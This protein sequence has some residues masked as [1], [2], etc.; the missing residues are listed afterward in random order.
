MSADYDAIPAVRWSH[1]K[2]IDRSP[3]HYLHA[4]REPR[5]DTPA[6]RFGR[7][8]HCLVLEPEAWA[9]RY[10]VWDGYRRGKA[11]DAF[12]E[13]NAHLEIVNAEEAARVRAIA[14]AI[15]RHPV[16]AEAL[17]H[18]VKEGVLTWTDEATGLACK[19]RFDHVNGRLV[20]LKTAADVDPRR[21]FAN[22][23]R[24]GYHAQLAFYLDGLRANGIEIAADPMI[25]CA[26]S[27]P[28]HDVVVY[29]LDA[30]V[31][32]QGRQMYRRLLARVKEC[33]ERGEWPGIA[34]DVKALEF[35]AWA[36]IEGDEHGDIGDI[37]LVA[38]E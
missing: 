14:A 29:A 9:E 6:F 19:G 31:I 17:A 4:T 8:V 10:A 23:Y 15:R 2:H 21:F 26:E 38:A 24:Y 5:P 33:T 30:M 7:A 27:V 36:E 3:L 18:G 35:P 37:G 11:W 22:A 25:V 34:P 1:L 12:A 16:A 20:D 32:D 28:P 13:A